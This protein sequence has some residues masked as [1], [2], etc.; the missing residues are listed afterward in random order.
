MAGI[1]SS[2]LPWTAKDTSIEF[3]AAQ[4]QMVCVVRVLT[5]L[6]DTEEAIAVQAQLAVDLCVDLECH[7]AAGLLQL[8]E[9]AL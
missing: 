2:E 3:E 1:C 4:R 6:H 7:G 9:L 5:D 8:S